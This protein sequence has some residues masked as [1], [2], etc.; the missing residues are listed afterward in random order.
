MRPRHNS[1]RPGNS[2][3]YASA[4]RPDRSPQSLHYSSVS[5]IQPVT[6][7]AVKLSNV[8]SVEEFKVK[9]L[10]IQKQGAER[11]PESSLSLTP[12]VAHRAAAHLVTILSARGDTSRSRSRSARKMAEQPLAANKARPHPVSRLAVPVEVNR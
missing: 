11:G 8:G 9:L 10:Q 3:E 12:Q 5:F 2:K 6:S 4:S 7:D 1:K